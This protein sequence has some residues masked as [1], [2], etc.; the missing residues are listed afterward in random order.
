MA[1]CE[2]GVCG[3]NSCKLGTKLLPCRHLQQKPSGSWGRGAALFLA[4][5]VFLEVNLSQCLKPDFRHFNFFFHAQIQYFKSVSR[6]ESSGLA[7]KKKTKKHRLGNES[8]NC[9]KI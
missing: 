7:S 4:N 3:L 5:S 8:V 6:A 2:L 9:S 1:W